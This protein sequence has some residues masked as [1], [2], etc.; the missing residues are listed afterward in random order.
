MLIAEKTTKSSFAELEVRLERLKAKILN[1]EEDCGMIILIDEDGYMDIS[2]M[3]ARSV[4]EFLDDLR[5][6][7]KKETGIE[8][9]N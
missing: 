8:E 4:L 2:R 7:V 9:L 6:N 3:P 1:K 5:E